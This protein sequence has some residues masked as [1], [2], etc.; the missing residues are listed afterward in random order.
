MAEAR[1]YL[2][3]LVAAGGR[4]Q[5]EVHSFGGTAICDWIDE[6]AAARDRF[7]PHVVV[8][9]FA[10]NANGGC[11]SGATSG[12]AYADKYLADARTATAV[13]GAGGAWVVWTIPPST[14]TIDHQSPTSP[15]RSAYV[16]VASEQPGRVSTIDGGALLTPGGVYQERLPCLAGERCGADGWNVV[17]NPDGVHFCPTATD[18]TG[19]C[20]VHSSGALRYATTILSRGLGRFG[21]G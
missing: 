20:D 17:R 11:M 14:R 6:M 7:T 5:V 19:R 21:I 10:G 18:L 9:S 4:A 2:E 16:Q 15:I 3:Y 8:M 13:A 12:T 1:L